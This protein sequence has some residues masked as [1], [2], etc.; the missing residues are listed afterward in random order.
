MNTSAPCVDTYLVGYGRAGGF[1]L[2]R[3][4]D[5]LE[6][7]RGDVV[8][9]RTR[10]GLELGQVL[11]PAG[12]RHARLLPGPPEGELLRPAT[13]ADRQAASLLR[14][15]EQGLFED[16][17]RLVSEFGLPAMV[18]DVEALLDG[19]HVL[20]QYLAWGEG[21]LDRLA[22]ALASRHGLEVLLEDLAP[23]AEPAEE[24]NGGCGEPNCGRAGGGGG[25]DSCS[26]GGG[27]STGCGSG[28]V[29]MRDYFAHL[30]TQMEERHR[31]P[32]L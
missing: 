23:V 28:K 18:L 11:C 10:R 14:R 8:V 4:A 20:V 22:E 31:V 12:D 6:C 1:A 2:F 27:C 25:C 5:S 16:C 32:L 26:S 13:A 17:Q 29:D 7:G 9:V 15:R 3:A 30:R 24:G 19:R 21:G